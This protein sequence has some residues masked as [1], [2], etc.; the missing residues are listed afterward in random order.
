MVPDFNEAVTVFART[1]RRAARDVF[2]VIVKNFRAGPAGSGVGHH[3]EVVGSVLLALVVA[4]ADH[5]LG[6]QA[7]LLGPDV[8]GFAV[9]NVD[10]G[11][12]FVCRQAVNLGQ[13]FPAPLERV[14]LE[15]VTKTP[16]AQHLEEGVMA[17]RVAHVFQVVVLATRAQAGLDR[18][19][20]HVG[21]LVGAQKNVLE[22]HHARVGEHQ[23]RVIAGHQRTGGDHGVSLGLEEVKK[24][25][26]DIGNAGR[27]NS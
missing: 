9:V 11:Q 4:D 3:P 13:E 8:V 22:L 25:L 26:A 19:R 23:G 5:A 14:A 21:A 1:A 16:V 6:R 20:T 27:N 17:C 10:R 15:I 24:Y 12:Q 2:A 18:G 7:N